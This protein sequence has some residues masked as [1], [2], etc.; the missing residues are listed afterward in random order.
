MADVSAI[1]EDMEVISADGVHVGVVD[2]IEGARMKLNRQDRGSGDK[3]H[4]LDLTHVAD[5]EGDKVRLAF[6]SELVTQFW[7]T[8]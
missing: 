4:F 1:R 7:E 6:N 8:E 2:R 5:V 3:H